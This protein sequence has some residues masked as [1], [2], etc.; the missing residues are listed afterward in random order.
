MASRYGRPSLL[1]RMFEQRSRKIKN[2]DSLHTM[3]IFFYAI[4]ASLRLR[5]TKGISDK[6]PL[7]V[8]AVTAGAVKL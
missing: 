2:D 6:A 5:Q 3:Y 7:E 4:Y 8:R 1:N